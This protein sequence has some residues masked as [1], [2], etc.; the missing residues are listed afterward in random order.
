[1]LEQSRVNDEVWLPLAITV[2]GDARLALI[3]S[4]RAQIDIAYRNYKKFQTESK[5]T[6]AEVQ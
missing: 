2:K 5:F 1:V 6:V 4:F 3:K